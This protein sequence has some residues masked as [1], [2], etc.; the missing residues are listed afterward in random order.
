MSSTKLIFQG[1]GSGNTE[2]HP[3]FLAH[4]H[5][6]LI[7]VFVWHLD[8]PRIYIRC[9]GFWKRFE[10]GSNFLTK[11]HCCELKGNLIRAEWWC[12]EPSFWSK[13]PPCENAFSPTYCTSSGKMLGRPKTS[14]IPWKWGNDWQL[15]AIK[16]AQA[17]HL[18]IWND[19]KVWN[20]HMWLVSKVPL[21]SYRDKLINLIG[22]L[23]Q[24]SG[25]K[26]WDEFIPNERSWSTLQGFSP[27]RFWISDESPMKVWRVIVFKKVEEYWY[28][29][30]NQ[31]SCV[32]CIHIYTHTHIKSTWWRWVQ[33]NI[34]SGRFGIVILCHFSTISFSTGW[35]L[36][37]SFRRASR[38]GFPNFRVDF[39]QAK[40]V[41][42]GL[43]VNLCRYRNPQMISNEARSNHY[44]PK[45]LVL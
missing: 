35:K 42:N 4:F 7:G 22:G 27:H 23:S 41:R 40:M 21:S 5:R 16:N 26:R 25:H 9:Y 13:G 43:S 10:V 18:F 19:L 8:K 15:L 31:V 29:K 28:P 11:H 33:H 38:Y 45:L 12:L 39:R 44:K 2:I 14:N 20:I 1:S 3:F 24:D 34:T 36:L 6:S 37:A 30:Q 17:M 32:I